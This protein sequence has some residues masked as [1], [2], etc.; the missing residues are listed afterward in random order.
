MTSWRSNSTNNAPSAKNS[1][2]SWTWTLVS[3]PRQ[4]LAAAWYDGRTSRRSPASLFVENGELV[5]SREDGICRYPLTQVR[6]ESALGAA[7]RRLFLPDNSFCETRDHSTLE[8]MLG[9][10]RPSLV[11]RME[12]SAVY[13]GAA[14]ALT[15][16]LLVGGYLWGLPWAAQHLARLVPQH[17]AQKLGSSTL[18]LL[19]R[20][21]TAPSKLPSRRQEELRAAFALLVPPSTSVP[22]WTL[23]FRT[24]QGMA[25]AFALPSGD[26]VVTDDLVSH[27]GTDEEILAILAHELGHVAHRHGLRRLI[28]SVGVTL[29]VGAL[30]GDFSDLATHAS[31]FLEL[32]YSRDMEWEADNY[33]IA[34]LRANN[35]SPRILAQALTSLKKTLPEQSSTLPALFSTHPDLDERIAHAETAADE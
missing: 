30:I 10:A 17:W 15:V 27:A 35:K 29:A 33:A 5:V 21:H 11:A 6:V 22:N 24:M 25:N 8:S 12:R 3:E 34:M 18:D 31:G 4:H 13:A 23:H 20:H 14:L 1:P 2:T 7:P 26:I 16:F 9:Q 28:Q 19:D 32:T